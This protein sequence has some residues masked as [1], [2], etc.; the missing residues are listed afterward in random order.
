M[1]IVTTLLA[2]AAVATIFAGSALAQQISMEQAKKLA[3][4]QGMT[5]VTEAEYD[6]GKW[7]L[8]GRDASNRKIEIDIDGNT[9]A[10]VKLERD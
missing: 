6:D 9:G 1:K 7:E 10:V 4:A 3:A 5:T 2:A 8:E